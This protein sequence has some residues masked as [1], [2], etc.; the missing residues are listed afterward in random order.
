MLVWSNYNYGTN[1]TSTS[2]TTDPCRSIYIKNYAFILK[3][4]SAS[5]TE[6]ASTH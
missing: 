3:Y 6:W 1:L 2:P 4:I 5:L